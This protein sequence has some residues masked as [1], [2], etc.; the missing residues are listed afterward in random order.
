MDED[1]W[2]GIVGARGQIRLGNTPW[3]MP[4]CAD[5]GTGSSDLTWQALLGVGYR[6]DWGEATFAWRAMGYE[7]DG[8]NVD[9]TFNGPGLG[10]GFRW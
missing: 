4:F 1:Y 10:V 3:F 9:L 7:L 2:D 6:F 5:I 8:D